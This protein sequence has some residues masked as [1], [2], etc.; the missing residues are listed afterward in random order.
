MTFLFR[1]V[2]CFD[3]C[4]I[5]TLFFY[6]PQGEMINVLKNHLRIMTHKF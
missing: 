1:M 2:K 3:L 4:L 6:T 5:K